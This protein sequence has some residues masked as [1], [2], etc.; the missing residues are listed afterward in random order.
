MYYIFFISSSVNGDLCFIHVQA[1]ASLVAQQV[2]N[3]PTMQ[4]TWV[5]SLGLEDIL[6]QGMAIHFSILAWRMPRTKEPAR[7]QSMGSQRVGHNRATKTQTHIQ[8]NV[9]RAA[10]NIDEHVS[11]QIMFFSIYAQERDCWIIYQLCFCLFVC[12][13]KGHL[14]HSPQQLYQFTFPSAVQESSL[15]LHILSRF[16]LQIFLMMA[17]LTDVK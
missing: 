7:L 10:M 12:F 6:E 13:F 15:F 9:K 5:R 16:S 2:Q 3:L 11:F 4:E 14:Y 8:A 17:I 1:R